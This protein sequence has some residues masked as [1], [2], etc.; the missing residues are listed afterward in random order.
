MI[1]LLVMVVFKRLVQNFISTTYTRRRGLYN[2]CIMV[3]HLG[4][5]QNTVLNSLLDRSMTEDQ[6]QAN[7]WWS[8]GDDFGQCPSCGLFY[9]L[10]KLQ[11][12][13]ANSS[14]S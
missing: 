11:E 8:F 13:R 10:G 6:L 14:L 3:H 12:H 2:D 5:C 7:L 4:L 9:F 1:F